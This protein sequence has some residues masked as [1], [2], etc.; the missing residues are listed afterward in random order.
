MTLYNTIQLAQNL[1]AALNESIANGFLSMEILA[2]KTEVCFS[3]HG[4]RTSKMRHVRKILVTRMDGLGD[5]V[6]TG[7]FLRELRRNQPQ[8]HISVI[9]KP[10]YR[11]VVELC[12]YINA[13]LCFDSTPG[14]QSGASRSFLYG[15]IDFAQQYLWNQ[16][17]DI[18]MTPRFDVDEFFDGFLCLV[19]GAPMRYGFDESV[20]PW[21]QQ[22]NRGFNA[23]YTQVVPD[24]GCAHEV[25]RSL[26]MVRFL[27]GNVRSTRMELW[28]DTADSAF[29]EQVLVGLTEPIAAVS[30][31]KFKDRRCWPIERYAELLQ[32]LNEKYGY[33]FVLLGSENEAEPAL[34]LLDTITIPRIVNL[35][36]KTKLR[37]MISVLYRCQL[38]IGRDTGTKHLAAA[39]GLP[40]VE[41]SC[42]SQDVPPIAIPSPTRYGPWGV[43][44][45]VVQPKA[46][47]QPCVKFCSKNSAHCILDVSVAQ[48]KRAVEELMVSTQSMDAGNRLKKE[49]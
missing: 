14:Y 21:K 42:H 39:A 37:Q 25:E 29:A 49:E 23:I 36:G 9:V 22:L 20:T 1:K 15:I 34:R 13:V 7:P 10:E 32:W 6:M 18:C 43:P 19:S 11:D 41:I 26:S 46:A 28:N 38:Y 5:L 33:S 16:R 8:A 35:V 12:P 24:M 45:V 27:N 3:A 31:G 30:I 47:T 4:F 17:F 44:N 40:V 48:V 2:K